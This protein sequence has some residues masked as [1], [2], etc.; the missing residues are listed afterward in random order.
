MSDEITYNCFHY[1]AINFLK[2]INKTDKINKILL[3]IQQ[4]KDL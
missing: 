3:R 1:N 4:I 2:S